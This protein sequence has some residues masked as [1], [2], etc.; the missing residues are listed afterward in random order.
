V[1][2]QK[3]PD[4]LPALFFHQETLEHAQAVGGPARLEA[5]VCEPFQRAKVGLA[6]LAPAV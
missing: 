4:V 5:P 1:L 6:Q 2:D 3:R